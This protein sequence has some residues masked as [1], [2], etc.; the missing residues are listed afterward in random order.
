LIVGLA[1]RGRVGRFTPL[2]FGRSRLE[3]GY[4]VCHAAS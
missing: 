2:R 4:I 3:F 1:R